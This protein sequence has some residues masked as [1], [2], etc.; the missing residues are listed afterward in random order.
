MHTL[1]SSSCWRKLLYGRAMP[2]AAGTI[3]S[4]A[5]PDPADNA[6]EDVVAQPGVLPEAQP[7]RALHSHRQLH[8]LLQ[9]LE[10]ALRGTAQHFEQ[11]IL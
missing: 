4:K 3:D 7:D 9:Q 2:S 1:H 8:A 6:D 11:R 5:H 10:Q